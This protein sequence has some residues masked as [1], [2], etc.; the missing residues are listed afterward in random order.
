MD[1]HYR[2][3]YLYQRFFFV[4]FTS[5]VFNVKFTLHSRKEKIMSYAAS[6][7]RKLIMYVGIGLSLFGVVLYDPLG[8]LF[9][10][11][12]LVVVT[13]GLSCI[14]A[15]YAY[16]SEGERVNKAVERFEKK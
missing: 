7:K 1:A 11:M 9:T 10:G 12:G 4:T 15:G 13:A 16:L 6:E 2:G 5:L 14:F 3:K 8:F